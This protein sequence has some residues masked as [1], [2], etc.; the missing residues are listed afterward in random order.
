MTAYHKNII[1][2]VLEL[3]NAPSIVQQMTNA[4]A[5]EQKRRV[6]FYNDINDD[7]KAEFI[8]GEVIIH[9]PVK[10]E[11]ND[12]GSNLHTLLSTFV[13]KNKCGY[14]GFEKIMVECKRNS[15]E[16]DICF[17]KTEKSQHFKEGQS[18]FPPPDLVVEILS[19]GTA[20]K[21]RGIKFTDY[22]AHE[23]EEYWIID[24]IKKIVEQ[25]RLED[26]DSYELILKSG[27]GQ[28]SCTPVKDFNIP[29]VAIFD[30]EEN[31]KAL[32][33]ILQ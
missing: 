27:E 9:S 32:T 7:Q 13:K 2:K 5:E 10:K 4:L 22:A 33:S 29:I 18:L 25:Y 26:A 28:I 3:P 24:S 21:D 12:A 14:V 8:N 31:L 1:E 23:V 6:Q 20:K 16:P 11:H 15:Y 30:P 17:F 19:K